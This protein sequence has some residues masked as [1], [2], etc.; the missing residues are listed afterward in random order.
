VPLRW[1]KYS[2]PSAA[3]MKPKAPLDHELL[4]GAIL[5]GASPLFSNELA[6]KE[7]VRDEERA[8]RATEGI[9]LC[10]NY[11]GRPIAEA[12]A[13]KASPGFQ[14][15]PTDGRSAALTINERRVSARRF[16]TVPSRI[17]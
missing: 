10:G 14:R 13:G 2:R 8:G 4:D 5:H 17:D 6:L 1:K 7:A 11:T 15:E 3:A 16:P 9:R 12:W